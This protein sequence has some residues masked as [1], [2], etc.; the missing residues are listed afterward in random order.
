[1]NPNDPE[2]DYII[3][4]FTWIR[5]NMRNLLLIHWKKALNVAVEP[6]MIKDLNEC[7]AK[8]EK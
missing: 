2:A 5:K 6:A 1:M 8:A 7:I 3:V 4:I